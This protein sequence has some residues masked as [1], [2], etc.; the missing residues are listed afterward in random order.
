MIIDTL[1]QSYNHVSSLTTNFVRKIAFAITK[2]TK[3]WSNERFTHWN[4]YVSITTQEKNKF[5]TGES[6]DWLLKTTFP[7][8][9]NMW[10]VKLNGERGSLLIKKRSK[11]QSVIRNGICHPLFIRMIIHNIVILWHV[12]TFDARNGK[13]CKYLPKRLYNYIIL[14]L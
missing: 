11:I 6:K 5:L 2:R 13:I 12:L 10:T 1:R 14:C 3:I 8:E 9:P 4:F 7:K